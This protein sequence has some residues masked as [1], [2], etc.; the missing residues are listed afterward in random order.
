METEK[1]Q[2]ADKRAAMLEQLARARV[3]AAEK[4]RLLGDVRRKEKAAKDEELKERIKKLN[5]FKDEAKEEEPKEEEPKP[6]INKK[7]T[8]KPAQKIIEISDTS[9]DDATS[10]ES[11][12]DDQRHVEYIVMRKPRSKPRAPRALKVKEPKEYET[13]KLTAE[14]AKDLLKQR[15]MSDAQKAAF[16]SLFPYHNF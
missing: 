2:V 12:S 13:S 3:K 10:D 9:S 6:K 11:D 14:V 15:V 1:P 4:R 16:A 7:T 8:K 5:I